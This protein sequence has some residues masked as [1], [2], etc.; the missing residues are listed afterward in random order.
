MGQWWLPTY[1]I[2]DEK[3][4]DTIIELGWSTLQI[5]KEL[6]KVEPYLKIEQDMLVYLDSVAELTIEK[7]E[8]IQTRRDGQIHNNKLLVP[9]TYDTVSR[10]IL[11]Y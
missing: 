6:Q 4:R 7:L 2:D 11:P 10:S 3:L 5:V 8:E 9:I 1:N